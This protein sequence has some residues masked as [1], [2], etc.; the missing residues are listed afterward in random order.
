MSFGDDTLDPSNGAEMYVGGERRRYERPSWYYGNSNESVAMRAM[1]RLILEQPLRHR[2]TVQG[3]GMLRMYIPA[4]GQPKRLR[5]NMWNSKYS[6]P[7]VSIMHDHPWDFDSWI[8]NGRFRNVRYVPVRGPAER[9]KFMTIKCGED[10]CAMSAPQN[11][12]LRAMPVEHYSTGDKY[13]QNADEIHASYYNDGTIT[14]NDRVGDTEHA[15]VFWKDEPK[16]YWVDAKP[17]EATEAE[18]EDSVALA[19][20]DWQ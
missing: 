12:E 5:L 4:P 10:G 14:L 6:V 13:H 20:K 8:I 16:G 2:W 9:Y 3:F 17:R 1:V 7:G 11:I 18:I 19:L 15:R